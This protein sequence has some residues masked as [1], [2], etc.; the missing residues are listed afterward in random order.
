MIL[1]IQM[2]E[3]T[4]PEW[5]KRQR[6]AKGYTQEQ[7]A[8]LM[9]CSTIAL[10]K[11][12]A[13]ERRPSEQVV[14][15]FAEIFG[16]SPNERE[17]FLRF[18]RRSVGATPTIAPSAPWLPSTSPRSNLPIPLTST[19]GREKE[20]CA[21]NQYLQN[22]EMRLI[23]LVGPPGIGK[24]RLSIE[25][26]RS[27]MPEFRDGIF[28]VDFASI[29]DPASITSTVLQALRFTE[30]SKQPLE[31][32][33]SNSIGDKQLLLVW[34]NCEH[35]IEGIAYLATSLL[36]KCSYLR[37][38][39]SSR[40][41]LRT[42]GE[43]E[44]PVPPLEIPKTDAPLE[45]TDIS[46]DISSLKLFAERARAVRPDF[47]LNSENIDAVARICIQLDGIPL[48]IELLAACI[49]FMPPQTLLKRMT[50]E[51]V[52]SAD[53]KRARYAHQK[54][55]SEAIMWSYQSLSS[56][57]QSLLNH[58][59]IFFGGFTLEAAEAIFTHDST[60]AVAEL[61][62]ALVDK[63]LL[64]ITYAPHR[65]PRY[66][67]LKVIQQFALH[68]LQITG[69]E[70]EVSDRHLVYFLQFVEQ[71]AQQIRGAQQVEWS[72]RIENEYNNL[73][74]ALEWA[75]SNLKTESAL[76]ILGALGWPW[77]IRGHYCEARAWLEKIRALPDAETYPLLMARALNHIGRHQWTQDTLDEACS[78]LEESCILSKRMGDEGKSTLAEAL[79]WLGLM[80]IGQN[81][82]V[83][84]TYLEQS[85]AL[86]RECHQ[87]RG[88]TLNMFHLG[89]L[90]SNSGNI[91]CA[92]MLLHQ[93]LEAFENLGDLFFVSRVCIFLGY[94]FLRK[95][96]YDQARLF[97][98]RH[99]QID[100]Q[101]HFWDGIA[102]GWRDLGNLF[103][104]QG[105]SK[106]AEECYERGRAVCR[107]RGL[108]KKIP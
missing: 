11:M 73:N 45:F 64:Q 24:T 78:L 59:A 79:N 2:N 66:T 82:D 105:D 101:L 48:A 6:K 83:A 34:D 85:L 1:F 33:L 12:E 58:L 50:S 87:E 7:L 14:A 95:E 53:V 55:L 19:I 62:Q 90:E 67:M 75:V 60:Q 102:E 22:P 97:F 16:I 28:F 21:L 77:E 38:L 65:E 36:S 80:E 31:Q 40:E 68:Q 99:L 35:L 3:D 23:T 93:S 94:L 4:F 43:W 32:H 69:F 70:T 72:E 91:E 74:A 49:R 44:F 107:E 20:L 106:N 108:I 84:R 37:I 61:I 15:R 29:N 13:G 57:E 52:L 76:R 17:A 89:I 8:Q 51:F 9:S 25:A 98:E 96:E 54:T 42:P 63:S 5:L 10:R 47:H 88:I 100:T 86:N 103:H 41:A 39:A 92:Q 104:Q 81:N 71:G 18:A 56:I 30:L 46:P 27:A 26:S